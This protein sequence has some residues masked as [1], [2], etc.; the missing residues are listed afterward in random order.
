MRMNIMKSYKIVTLSFF[1]V[2]IFS[3]KLAESTTSSGVDKEALLDRHNFYR[4]QVGVPHLKWSDEL[5]T[6]AQEWANKLA[7]ECDLYHSGSNYGES[8]Y[9]SGDASTGV[10]AVNYWASEEAYFDHDN[11][12]FKQENGNIYGHYTQIIW[13]KTTH[14]G[15]AFADCESG[16]R[17]WV[18]NYDPHGNVV[19]RKVY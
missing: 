6:H 14:V 16:T 3:F 11:R 13:R 17:I 8:I 18:C 1:L 4:D 5:A 7:K 12:M 10:H 15:G 2:I 19:G 9:M